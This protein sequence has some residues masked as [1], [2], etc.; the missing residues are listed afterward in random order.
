ML[1]PHKS[2]AAI[3]D[4]RAALDA[5]EPSAALCKYMAL[6]DEYDD[7]GQSVFSD[8]LRQQFVDERV[9]ALQ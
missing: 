5:D 6:F 9:R 3:A 2:D 1:H 7:C 4:L 8:V